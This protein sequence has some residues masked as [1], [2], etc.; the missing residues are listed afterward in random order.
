MIIF[1]NARKAFDKIQSL[2]LIKVLEKLEK[3]EKFLKTI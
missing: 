2:F 1:L 3:E